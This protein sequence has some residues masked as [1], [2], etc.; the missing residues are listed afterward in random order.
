VR[1]EVNAYESASTENTVHGKKRIRIYTIAYDVVVVKFNWTKSFGEVSN[2][3]EIL[4]IYYR[5]NTPYVF[6]APPPWGATTPAEGE[7]DHAQPRQ[8]LIAPTRGGGCGL[9][10][11][12]L[13]TSG[14]Y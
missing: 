11:S 14:R 13:D 2:A 8:S 7:Q 5:R 4:Y 12:C 9:R 3:C 1:K 10:R 6:P